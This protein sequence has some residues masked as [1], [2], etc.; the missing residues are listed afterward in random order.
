MEN[1]ST[2]K[3]IATNVT[4]AA[5]LNCHKRLLYFAHNFVSN[6]ITI[7]NNYHFFVIMENKKLQR[8]N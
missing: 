6:L 7:D 2:Q 4:S 1:V 8:K 5:S 3:T